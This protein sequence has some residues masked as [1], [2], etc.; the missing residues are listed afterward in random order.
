MEYYSNFSHIVHIQIGFRII[1]KYF[2]LCIFF[3]IKFKYG[4]FLKL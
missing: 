1:Y 3:H 4:P 2:V